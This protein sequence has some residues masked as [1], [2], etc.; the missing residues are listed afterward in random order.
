MKTKCSIL[1]ALCLLCSSL[2]IAQHQLFDKYAEMDNVTSVYISKAMFNM[3]PVIGDVGLSLMNMKGKVESLQLVS[4]EQKD[5]IPQMREEF[6]RLVSSRH[7]ELMRVRD[8]KTRATFY[9][10][11]NGDQVK[12]LL[13]LADTDSSFTVIQLLGNFTLKDIQEIAGEMGK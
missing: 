2:A 9:A 7:Q 12:D 5:R 1:L 11:M 4:T 8:G 3:M 10:D 13:M 6:T